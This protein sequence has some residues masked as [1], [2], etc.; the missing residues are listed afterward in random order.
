MGVG[1]GCAVQFIAVFLTTQ[2]NIFCIIN[3]KIKSNVGEGGG[4]GIICIVRLVWYESFAFMVHHINK[5]EVPDLD[6]SS[7]VCI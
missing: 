2:D 5:T 7:C 3:N 6:L 4:G 1:W